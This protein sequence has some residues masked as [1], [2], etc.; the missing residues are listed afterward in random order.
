MMCK[1]I[2]SGLIEN[3]KGV[4]FDSP[5]K[6]S[7]LTKKDIEAIKIAKKY[8]IKN[9]ALS[10]ANSALDVNLLKSLIPYKINLISKIESRSGFLK[11]K[12]IIKAS[13]Q[14][15]ID[16]GDLS[17]YIDISKIP[18]AQK[19]IFDDAKKL[20]TNVLVATNLLETMIYNNEPTRA[21]SN[22]IFS[23]LSGGCK[24]LVLAAETAIGKYPIDSINFLNKCI[25]VFNS[26]S[27]FKTKKNYIFS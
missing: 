20:K 2:Q 26:R 3:N 18:I 21:E 22:D 17:R 1:V 12:E 24:G 25:K 8:K 6:L 9:F 14:V 27:K 16:R 19:F 5:V 10:F 15:L 11:R 23:L 4:H 13:S 7:P